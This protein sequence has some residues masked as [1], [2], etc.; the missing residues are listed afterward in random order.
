[1]ANTL[2]FELYGNDIDRIF[3]RLGLNNQVTA[4]LMGKGMADAAKNVKQQLQPRL[5]RGKSRYYTR[6]GKRY[7][8]ASGELRQSARSRRVATLINGVKVSGSGAIVG[9]GNRKAY[10][11]HFL[12]F[13]TGARVQRKTG[14]KTGRV[15]AQ[16]YLQRTLARTRS[17][18]QSLMLRGTRQELARQI[19]YAKGGRKSLDRTLARLLGG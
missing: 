16:R 13:G 15:T 12:E 18:N 6:R 2:K 5:P 17:S 8:V 14:R 3:R 1:M 11:A 4:R 10:Y 19:R 9:Y 7:K